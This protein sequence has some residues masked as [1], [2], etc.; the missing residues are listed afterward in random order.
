MRIRSIKLD[1]TDQ[2]NWLDVGGLKLG[3]HVHLHDDLPWLVLKYYS[4]KL[5]TIV[6][7]SDWHCT[8]PVVDCSSKRGL[9]VTLVMQGLLITD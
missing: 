3:M 6:L 4:Y 7:Y 9:E 1:K 8:C 2:N 5:A